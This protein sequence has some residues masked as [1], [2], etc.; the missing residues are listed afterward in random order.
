[1]LVLQFGRKPIGPFM[2]PEI[3]QSMTDDCLS[4]LHLQ[5][6]LQNTSFAKKQEKVI[7]CAKP[8]CLS[9]MAS[10]SKRAVI[11]SNKY[12]PSHTVLNSRANHS[13]L[14]GQ[15]QANFTP[16]QED[17]KI[18]RAFDPCFKVLECNAPAFSL[19]SASIKLASIQQESTNQGWSAQKWK[20]EFN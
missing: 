16:K 20:E 7:E 18:L 10:K 13:L 4:T 12:S 11:S 1:M 6:K 17:F 8:D 19:E 2:S 5:L 9:L 3:M 15:N 14:Q